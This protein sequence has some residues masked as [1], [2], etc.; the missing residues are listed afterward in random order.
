MIQGVIEYLCLEKEK[1]NGNSRFVSADLLNGAEENIV[2]IPIH[3]NFVEDYGSPNSFLNIQGIEKFVE[4][5]PEFKDAIFECKQGIFQKGV[6]SSKN[7]AADSHLLTVSEVGKMSK[8]YFNVINPD[9]VVEEYGADCFRLYEMFLGPLEQAKPWDTKGIDGVSKFLRKFWAL[10]FDEK[11]NWSVGEEEPSREELKVLHQCIKKVQEDMERFS[12]NTCVSAF[13]IATNELRRLDSRK[14]ALLEPL[15]I[16][17]APFAPHLAEELWHRLGKTTT[18]VNAVYP[19]WSEEFLAEDFVTYPISINGKKRATIDLPV[20]LPV[21]E[22]EQASLGL[23]A[24]QKWLE[25]LTVRKMIV[26]PNRVVNI[27]AN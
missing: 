15:T 11:G 2:K 3:V 9:D 4:W 13:M 21:Q 26:I 20:D 1:V 7:G 10:F 27:V 8:R 16:L 14:R 23:P 24:V 19:E 5:R 22:V 17:I 6:F 12:L 25:G 18:V